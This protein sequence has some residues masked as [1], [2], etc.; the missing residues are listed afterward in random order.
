[1]TALE[2]IQNEIMQRRGA[3]Q[4]DAQATARTEKPAKREKTKEEIEDY[5]QK[6]IPEEESK[7]LGAEK[8]TSRRR[9]KKADNAIKEEPEM[10]KKRRRRRTK[11]QMAQP[12]EK[13]R[14]PKVLS[15]LKP[16]Y[17]LKIPGL[18]KGDCIAI[19]YAEGADA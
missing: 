1:M 15:P 7:Y 13:T 12:V 14:A 3:V 18:P 6:K 16:L 10:P 11:E 4:P 19:C 5:R 17:L 2:E 8:K 9:R